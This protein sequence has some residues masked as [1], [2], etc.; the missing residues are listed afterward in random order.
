MP[1]QHFVKAKQKACV[2]ACCRAWSAA[3]YPGQ[4]DLIRCE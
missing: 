1:G 3:C 4:S 2:A